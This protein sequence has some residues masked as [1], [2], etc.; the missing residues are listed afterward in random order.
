M[1]NVFHKS[2]KKKQVDLSLAKHT[3]L[4]HRPQFL[5]IFHG[6]IH[7]PIGDKKCKFYFK[8]FRDHK[9]EKSYYI[10]KSLW[11][12]NIEEPERI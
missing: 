11:G 7:E 6:K 10:K 4:I 12:F 8:I 3:T 9:F 2:K 5:H 1:D